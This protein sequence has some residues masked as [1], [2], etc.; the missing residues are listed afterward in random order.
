MAG[1]D[2]TLK[3]VA[4][5]AWFAGAA[6]AAPDPG[7]DRL[8]DAAAALAAARE[9]AQSEPSAPAE[10]EGAIWV[11]VGRNDLVQPSWTGSPLGAPVLT[12]QRAAVFRVPVDKLP[13]LSHFMHD[14]FGRCGGF[15]AHES[16]SQAEQDLAAPPPAPSETFTVDQ[17]DVVR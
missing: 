9:A 1:A 15:F 8:P 4:A 3:A 16:R 7:F 11:S 14:K 17:G 5:L 13:E 10:G 2:R 12:S 6:A